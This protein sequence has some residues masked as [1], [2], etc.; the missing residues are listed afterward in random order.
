[1][2]ESSNATA[3]I[4]IPVKYIDRENGSGVPS[5]VM[6][7]EDRFGLAFME[8]IVVR[9]TPTVTRRTEKTCVFEY[10]QMQLREC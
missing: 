8:D 5:A 2:D 9:P 6:M 10:L 1:M 3:S 4:A 7:V